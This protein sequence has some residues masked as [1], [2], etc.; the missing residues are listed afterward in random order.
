MET[1]GA[2]LA[3]VCLFA[4][5]QRLWHL[6]HAVF[7]L[8][9]VAVAVPL[10]P[11]RRRRPGAVLLV[12]AVLAGAAPVVGPVIA[13]TAYTVALDTVR[14]RHRVRLLGGASLL[15]MASATAAGPSRGPG[16]AAYGLELGLLL[17]VTAVVVPGLVGTVYG[18]QAR[19]LR[20]LRERGDAA[21]R[22]RRFADSEARTHERSRIAAEMHD[23]VGHRL[24]LISLHAGG[25][26]LALDQAAPELREEAVLVRRTTRDAMREL[27]QALGVLGPLG[28]DTGPDA[29]TDATGTRSDVEA[30]VA[31]SRDG[32]I[33][34]RLEWSGP[35]LGA[36]PARVRRAV[37]RVV[38]E[39]LTNVHRYATA[40][41][42]TVRIEQNDPTVRVTVRNGASPASP[43]TPSEAGTGRGLTGLR[44]RV[45]LLGGT[46]EA[47]ALPSGGFQVVAT[48]P[49]E[50]DDAVAWKR[51]EGGA[52]ASPSAAPGDAAALSREPRTAGALTLALGAV[53]LWVLMALAIGLVY[54][55]PRHVARP[56]EPRLGMTYQELA[57][58][59]DIPAVRAAAT[60]N[61]PPRP[62]GTVGCVYS[63]GGSGARP[64][65]FGV[66][67]Y[68]FNASQRL[69][70]IDRF[71]VPSVRDTP[72]WETP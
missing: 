57:G 37:H 69:V 38:R 72:P 68:C 25:L 34:V 10:F 11:L 46:F 61:E 40:A 20:A 64:G 49:A 53:A 51:S 62:A 9:V 26:E 22:A 4:V 19:L 55:Q 66:I 31:E 2:A 67:R 48:V 50:P 24:S 27:R 30:L 6:P 60:G 16:S 21:E 39:A 41:H 23:L 8:C 14:P 58:V 65:S 3:A 47:G 43:G 29:L 56:V 44:E 63:P 70:S 52:E 54:A 71:T 1:A 45:E 18:Q 5:A 15:I 36:C 28:R 42:V 12:L 13:A 7:Q 35:D 32:G 59:V 33:A 17:A